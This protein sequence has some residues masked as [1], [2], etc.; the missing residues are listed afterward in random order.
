MRTFA[1]LLLFT[2]VIPAQ[3]QS[4]SAPPQL[5]QSLADLG[6]KDS[7]V[8]SAA[9]A[10]LVTLGEPAVP[11]LRAIVAAAHE[12][13]QG[14]V[15]RAVQVLQRIGAPAAVAIPEMLALLNRLPRS[16]NV[17]TAVIQAL[18]ALAPYAPPKRAA[19]RDAMFALL[20]EEKLDG[21]GKLLQTADF[22]DKCRTIGRTEF[23]PE[24]TAEYLGTRLS[25]DN[26]FVREHAAELLAARTTAPEATIA[27]LLQAVRGPHPGTF[28]LEGLPKLEVFLDRRIQTAAARALLRVAPKDPRSVEAFALLAE[29]PQ[30]EDRLDAIAAVR[31]VG[32]AAAPMLPQ[33]MHMAEADEDVVVRREVI[34]TLGTLGAVATPAAALLERLGADRDP[35]VAK[36]ARAALRQVRR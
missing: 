13:A 15:L 4:R 27:A 25:D 26:P 8:W 19:V 36:R 29:R 6:S 24:A 22:V 7:R 30:A 20:A 12:G 11:A 28:E 31:H 17:R 14:D 16:D 35:Q 2:A 23:G 1:I 5:Q 33:L 9:M 18:G 21:L 3:Q 10:Q 34:T 32:A